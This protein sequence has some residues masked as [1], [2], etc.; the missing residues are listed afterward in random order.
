[1]RIVILFLASY[2][3]MGASA[4]GDSV[5]SD[6]KPIVCL[7]HDRVSPEEDSCPSFRTV[8]RI[9]VFEWCL[10]VVTRSAC[11]VLKDGESAESKR[12]SSKA[13]YTYFSGLG[14]SLQ[15][16]DIHVQ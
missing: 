14:G 13:D 1:M 15:Q 12:S 16:I 6:L 7:C 3:G 10:Y 11:E 2:N 4:A 9:S 5:Q 8:F